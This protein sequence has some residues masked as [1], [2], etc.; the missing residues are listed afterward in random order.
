MIATV[1]RKQRKRP[2]RLTPARVGTYVFLLSA[3]AFF[4]MPLYVM[5]VTSV[6]PMEEIRLGNIF[7]LP[8]HGTLG[9]W[10]SAWTSARSRPIRIFSGKAG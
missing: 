3:A 8:I 9:P 1:S 2:S 4:L 5:L 6:K 7:A 10:I